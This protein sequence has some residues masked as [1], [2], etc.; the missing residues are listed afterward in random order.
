MSHVVRKER[1]EKET[2][3]AKG[4]PE[5]QALQMNM[6]YD[7]ICNSDTPFT[8]HQ[9]L[10]PLIPEA[11]QPHPSVDLRN[12]HQHIPNQ[13]T[14]TNPRTAQWLITL[15]KGRATRPSPHGIGMFGPLENWSWI[16][17]TRVRYTQNLEVVTGASSNGVSAQ[18]LSK[19]MLE[20]SKMNR[21]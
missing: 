13:S 19:R 1:K 9:S 2:N 16:L 8:N 11:Q 20:I 12:S 17:I 18:N 21:R 10:T 14:C 4:L 15:K 6:E 7:G 3:C 5:V